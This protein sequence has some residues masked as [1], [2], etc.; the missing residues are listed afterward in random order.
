[1]SEKI[2]EIKIINESSQVSDEEAKKLQEV[3]NQELGIK[4]EKLGNPV[5]LG[6]TLVDGEIDVRELPD[7][8]FKQVLVRLNKNVADGFN[9]LIDQL[10]YL[11]LLMLESLAPS[12]KAEVMKRLDAI[13]VQGENKTKMQ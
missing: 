2:N 11:T 4:H 1:M 10:N 8:D 13:R 7:K 6:L 3:V 5:A 9:V 12:K